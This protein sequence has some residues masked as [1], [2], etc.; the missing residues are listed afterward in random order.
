MGNITHC[1]PEPHADQSIHRYGFVWFSKES[2][3]DAAVAGTDNSFWH[4]RRI[5]VTNRD[6]SAA[7]AP[8]ASRT[9]REPMPPSRSLYIG[10]IPYETTDAELNRVFKDLDNVKDVRVA[11]DRTTGWP[12]GF[13]HADFADI[14]SATKGR[15]FLKT[16][17]LAGRQLKVDFATES[18]T[19]RSNES[20]N[21]KISDS[22]DFQ[23]A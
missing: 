14:E 23:S 5:A 16:V 21:T 18:A 11:V 1:K 17:T 9:A 3:R 4:G 20:S 22:N 2:E 8:G 6:R 10:N 15:D 12:R 19:L 13:A 7:R